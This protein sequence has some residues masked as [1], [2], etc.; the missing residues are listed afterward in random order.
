MSQCGSGMRGHLPLEV[1]LD[2]RLTVGNPLELEGCRPPN[3][4]AAV[5]SRDRRPRCTRRVRTRNGRRRTPDRGSRPSGDRVREDR[6]TSRAGQAHRGRRPAGRN[7]RSSR[8]RPNGGT[9][10]RPIS[11]TVTCSTRPVRPVATTLRIWASP[12]S[13]RCRRTWRS[14]ARQ[15]A[16]MSSVGFVGRKGE[17]G[18]DRGGG[19]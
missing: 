13:S 14:A 5:T 7:R 4:W 12:G 1:H 19:R 8:C 11:S 16:S 15:A 6:C 9:R 2:P 3:P 17:D 10:H 18:C